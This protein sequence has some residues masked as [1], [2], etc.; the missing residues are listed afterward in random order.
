MTILWTTMTYEVDRPAVEV[1]FFIRHDADVVLSFRVVLDPIAVDYHTH[2]E[3]QDF[4]DDCLII[5]A[6]T[7]TTT[8]WVQVSLT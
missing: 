7:Y 4:V 5:I 8:K 1:H 3:R 2:I 6:M